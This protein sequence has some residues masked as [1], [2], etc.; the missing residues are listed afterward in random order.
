VSSRDPVT[1]RK[2]LRSE[3]IA[4]YFMGPGLW[5]PVG[6]AVVGNVVA[7]WIDKKAFEPLGNGMAAASGGILAILLALVTYQLSALT[8]D[9]Y[10]HFVHSDIARDKFQTMLAGIKWGA[11]MA[12][13][14][15]VV[16]VLLAAF[17]PE[18]RFRLGLVV[19]GASASHLWAGIL[20]SFDFT[21]IKITI[22]EKLEEQADQ[23]RP[24]AERLDPS[25]GEAPGPDKS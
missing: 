15:A 18:I 19:L 20:A 17:C 22:A 9:D 12:A 1:L 13:V 6:F 11:L 24:L 14:W 10:R 8:V 4:W 3:G 23:A 2:Y 21:Q 5:M 7:I 25:L 16:A